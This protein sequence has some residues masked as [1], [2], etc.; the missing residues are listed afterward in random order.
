MSRIQ[1]LSPFLA[2]QIAAGEVVERPASIVKELVE[3]SL[4]AE[5]SSIRV[6]VE[7]GGVK[8]V[9]VT[10]DGAGIHHDDLRLALHRHA[11]SKIS[12]PEDLAA[13]LTLGFR[14]EA[15]ASMASVA[16]VVLTSRTADMAQ[17]WTIEVHGGGE[18]RFA[19]NAHPVGTTVDVSDLFFNTLARRK[20]L[21]TERTE[22][23][24][25]E[26]VFRRLAL[27]HPETAMQLEQQGR[28]LVRVER[29]VDER[30]RRARLGQLVGEELA[31]TAVDID[32]RRGG[33]RLSG[34]VGRPTLSRSQADQQYFFVNGRT[35]RDKLV[36]HAVRQAYRDVLFHGRHPVFV[37]FLELPAEVVDVNVHPTKHEVRFRD[38][39]TVHDFVFGTLNRV[40]RDDRPGKLPVAEPHLPATPFP[41]REPH[42]PGL[43]FA[44]HEDRVPV[45]EQIARYRSLAETPS[46][47][48]RIHSAPLPQSGT[49]PPLGYA[50][51]QIHGVYVLAQ[52]SRG[53]VVVD[54]HAAHERITYEGLKAMRRGERATSQQLLVP[55]RVDVSVVQA[56]IAEAAAGELATLGLVLDRIGPGTLVVRAVPA[57]LGDAEPIGLI[58]DVLADLVEHGSSAH[59][60]ALEERL[61]ATMACHASVR[62]HRTLTIAEMNALL[63]QMEVTENAGQCNH[64]R[65]T[66][67]EYSLADLDKLFLR[68]R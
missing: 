27:S 59:V 21:K 44:P 32:E 28:T 65:P 55:P 42:A 25:I 47:G 46:I 1:T 51:G 36:A 34:W 50:V 30:G 49:T 56:D 11:T 57:L 31:Q 20:F 19:P 68:G 9:R 3:N 66:F 7:L 53:L 24:H 29:G 22:L 45:M 37:L 60:A 18:L 48:S 39:R 6:A 43:H 26:D 40:L 2:N 23:L 63:R 67:F 62:A 8:R 38:A 41:I 14:G 54:M 4:D 52:N 64:G 61:L 15:L 58:R 17:A 13:L 5:A 35:V 10:D 33:L 12:R 16:R